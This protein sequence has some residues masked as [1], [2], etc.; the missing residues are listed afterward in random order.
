MRGLPPRL[1]LPFGQWPEADRRL[2]ADAMDSNDDPFCDAP[3][4]RLAHATRQKSWFAWRRFLGFL[5]ISE[6]LALEADPAGRLTI[7]RVRLYVS[8]LAQTNK[9]QSVASQIDALYQTARILMPQQDWIW[10]RAVKARL[11]AAVPAPGRSRP[12]I[13]SV[14]SSTSDRN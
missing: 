9:P 5:A 10:L 7:E 2:W 11:H 1:H 14:S 13:T 4:A 8:H 12:V 3:G 6:P